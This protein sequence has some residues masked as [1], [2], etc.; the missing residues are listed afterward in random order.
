MRRSVALLAAASLACVALSLGLG[1]DAT[2]TA[3]PGDSSA[4]TVS[5]PA[6]GPFA[7][8][9]VTLSQTRDLVNQTV[10]LTWKGGAP[11]G[12][13]NAAL[14]STSFT[15]NYLQVMQCWGD[16]PSGPDREQCQFGARVGVD[17]RGGFNTPSRNVSNGAQLVDPLEPLKPP[18]GTD[19]PVLVPFRA[20]N[21]AVV[22]GRDN[23]FYNAGTTNE[24]PYARTRPDGTG[25]EF[26]EVQTALEA[27]GLGCGLVPP[28][29]S[30][31]RSCWMVVVPRSDHEVDGSLRVDNGPGGLVSSP[32]SQTNWQNRLAIPLSFVPIVDACKEGVERPIVGQ[33]AFVEAIS[34]WQPT[35]CA[36]GKR[37]YS[38]TQLADNLS[39]QKL[40]SDQP[41]L[42]VMSSPLAPADVPDDR[43]IVYAPLSLSAVVLGALVETA[44]ETTA[45]A[46]VLQSSGRRI[47]DLKLTPRLV[48]KLLTQSYR[49]GLPAGDPD[50]LRNPNNLGQDPEFVSLNP[51]FADLAY[52][53]GLADALV[54]P[55]ESDAAAL[56]WQYVFADADAR[57][58]LAGT[59]DPSGMVVNAVY[60]GLTTPPSDFPKASSYCQQVLDQT[61]LC[62]LDVRPYANDFHDAARDASRGDNLA[63]TQFDPN[64]NPP[65]YVASPPP[66]GGRRGLLAVTDAATA[67]RYGLTPVRLRNAAGAF[68]GPDPA[69]L[70]AA[71]AAMTPSA[72]PE[73]LQPNLSSSRADA[74]PLAML[75]YA[76][77][78][79]ALLDKAAASD[80]ADVLRYAAGAGQ[81]T[82]F[83]AGTLP[84]GYAPLPD[85]LRA[86]TMAAATQIQAAA[87]V[88]VVAATAEPQDALA[89]AGAGTDSGGGSGAA[90]TDPAEAGAAPVG[91]AA[92]A[93]AA[94][95]ETT[96]EITLAS[97]RTEH[98][99]SGA[100]RWTL[101]T[102][103]VLGVLAALV[104]PAYALAGP[105]LRGVRQLTTRRPTP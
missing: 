10:S 13:A 83:A 49:D 60:R 104:R 63:R 42:S 30:A 44:P 29:G 38:Y 19:S 98:V 96:P 72:V 69:A 77:A 101:L 36:G 31:P 91:Q 5:A 32:L 18:A 89:D 6:D 79:P 97:G 95:R 37:S 84:V 76:A 62:A 12:G 3:A 65:S 85:A 52:P 43:R 17:N 1:A 26:L 47:T 56:M 61:E 75:S 92:A 64:A 71:E 90:G 70:L 11:T 9:K 48:A 41:G 59:P 87:G 24:D 94:A 23:E 54:P 57:A 93:A 22:T 66:P 40:T 68:V 50:V 8:L 102:A 39:R 99:G 103:A 45:P 16:D 34:R 4:V 105:A 27:P 28:G 53:G 58:F 86:Q 35:L 51:Q 21:G 14:G 15:I 67:V 74:Y 80:Y 33:E 7:G 20:S 2:A 73:V 88:A 25:E 81:V 78:A 82:G 46:D 55:G 100:Q